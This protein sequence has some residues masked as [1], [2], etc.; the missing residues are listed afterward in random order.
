[1]ID[2]GLNEDQRMVVDMAKDFAAK[3]IL[4]KAK[5][6]DENHTFPRDIIDKAQELGLVNLDLSA[7][8]G[9]GNMGMVESVLI[10]EVLGHAC[11][12]IALALLTN[13][14]ATSPIDYFGTPEQKT[15]WLSLVCQERLLVSFCLTEPQTGSDLGSLK[16]HYEKKGSGYV[17]NGQK[18]WISNANQAQLYVVFAYPK[19]SQQI[20]ELSA[21]IV[22]AESPG[23]VK[24]KPEKKLG[25]KA[26]DTAGVV[27]EDVQVSADRLLA[28][29]GDGYRIAMKSLSR[30]RTGTAALATGIQQRCI[31][32]SI[33]YS[34]GRYA[35]GKPIGDHPVIRQYIAAM[36][37]AAEASRLASWRAA[38][39]GA[40]G[41]DYLYEAA[42]AKA[43]A[44]STAEEVS[45]KAVQIMG[46]A[47]ISLEYPVAKLVNDA[48]ILSIIEGTTEIQ[49]YTISEILYSRGRYAYF[50][51]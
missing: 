22:P 49:K 51:D 2:F 27:F 35:G 32:E 11:A 10:A 40:Q 23:I 36:Q 8:Y 37:M 1:M 46:G 12:G 45:L 42:L 16:T 20:S 44:T 17:I 25:L 9:G 33:Q 29:E 4:P 13:N 7:E 18:A 14:L 24:M 19:G 30:G 38:W 21:F 39:K 5:E 43:Y 31:D 34:R 28:R 48:K 15:K 3:E 6:Y 47:G 50:T 26:S 41:K